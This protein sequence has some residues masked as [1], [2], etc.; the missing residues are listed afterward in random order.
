MSAG[1]ALILIDVQNDYFPGG[2]M[3]LEGSL[4]AAEK[5]GQVLRFFRDW[6]LPTV[7][8][9]HLMLRPGATF[10]LP[11]TEG[12]KIHAAVFPGQDELVIRKHYP[13]SFRDTPLLLQL[14]Q[15]GVQR[16]ILCGM[17]THMCVDATVRAAF[18]LGFECWV[19]ENACATRSLMH[20][21]VTLPAVSVHLS[22]LAALNGVYARV[23]P[24]EE[25]IAG[26]EKERSGGQSSA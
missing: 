12:V 8:V 21:G 15:W 11:D 23:M 18:D 5:A 17:M 16:L 13:N 19:A 14:Q 7:H 25:I 3:E 26:L 6:K 1:T 9:Q 2:K 24:A 4:P 22:I 10:F 20:A